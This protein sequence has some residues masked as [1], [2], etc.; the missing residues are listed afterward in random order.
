MTNTATTT[1]TIDMS[2]F[3]ARWE[4]RKREQ[5]KNLIEALSTHQSIFEDGS[6]TADVVWYGGG[7]SGEFSEINLYKNGKA[8]TDEALTEI[9]DDL[10]NKYLD[11]FHGGCEI[12][13]GSSGTISIDKDGISDNLDYYTDVSGKEEVCPITD[14]EVLNILSRIDVASIE[15]KDEVI[16]LSYGYLS[17]ENDDEVSDELIEA[18]NKLDSNELVEFGSSGEGE[19]WENETINF[20]FRDDKWVYTCCFTERECEAKGES[21]TW[22]GVNE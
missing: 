17:T 9:A 10:A 6:I 2:D 14:Q 5:E 7:D 3:E 18:I 20:A 21:I 8:F 13:E 12:N 16:T 22:S 1:A 4:A 11:F 19:D 15:D